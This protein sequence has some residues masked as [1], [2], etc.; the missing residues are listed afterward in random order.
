MRYL[1]HLICLNVVL[2]LGGCSLQHLGTQPAFETA[3]PTQAEI[4]AQAKAQALADMNVMGYAERVAIKGVEA[5]ISA[6]L[7]T[8]ATTSSL[9]A[10]IV[11]EFERDGENYVLFRIDATDE[12]ADTADKMFEAK[13]VRWVRIVKKE[14]G[15]IRR[16]VVE[17]TV[18][19]GNHLTTEEFNLADRE[20]FMYPALIGRNILSKNH[21][22]V[23]SNKKKKTEPACADLNPPAADPAV[24]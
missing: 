3:Q 22:L 4:A 23:S 20:H 1:P 11:R 10:K 19:I 9:G 5:P 15:F 12:S 13:I 7:D 18:C 21:I 17:M 16:P 24:E 6:R 14:G 2:L 8:G